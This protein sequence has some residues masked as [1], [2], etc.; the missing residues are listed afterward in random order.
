MLQ[1]HDTEEDGGQ[2]RVGGTTVGGGGSHETTESPQ[3]KP[4]GRLTVFQTDQTSLP[5][6][7]TEILK[8]SDMKVS[9]EIFSKLHV[10][11]RDH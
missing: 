2:S 1:S 5:L 6:K 8:I 11:E 4:S 3:S 9:T 10:E 7:V